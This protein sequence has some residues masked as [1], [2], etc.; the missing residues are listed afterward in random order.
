M[1]SVLLDTDILIDHLRIGRRI[2]ASPV[3]ASYSSITRAELYSGR[4]ADEM[5]IDD[6][7]SLFEEIPVG[8][9]IAEEAGRIRRAV[10]LA[11][12]DAIIASTAILTGQALLTRNRRHFGSVPGLRFRGG[13]SR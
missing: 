6:L 3:E 10:G 5:V 2:P 12:P 9:R 1:A 8:R 13:G 4:G 11:L 7:L